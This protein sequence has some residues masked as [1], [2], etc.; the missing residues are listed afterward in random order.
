TLRYRYHGGLL[1]QTTGR[2]GLSFYFN[3]DA[4]GRCLHTWGDGGLMARSFEYDEAEGMTRVFDSK[5]NHRVYTHRDGDVERL[6]DGD[7]TAREVAYDAEF[8]Q[9]SERDETGAEHLTLRDEMGRVLEMVTAGGGSVKFVYDS[10][11]Q[12]IE[13]SRSDGLSYRHEYDEN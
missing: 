3:Y 1:V 13:E 4:K 11:D 6:S 7:G 9:C 5:G 2:D 12:L 8:R 10:R